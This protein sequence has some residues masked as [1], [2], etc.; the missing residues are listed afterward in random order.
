M[1]NY[2]TPNVL[3]AAEAARFLKVTHSYLNILRKENR[4]PDYTILGKSKRGQTIVYHK[5]ELVSFRK[6]MKRKKRTTAK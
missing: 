6:T 5:S 3:T 2:S 4:G 1:E